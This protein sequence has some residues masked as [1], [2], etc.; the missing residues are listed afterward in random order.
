[1]AN[2]RP[3]G[4]ESKL[5]KVVRRFEKHI[6]RR[7]GLEIKLIEDGEVCFSTDDPFLDKKALKY[8]ISSRFV[9]PRLLVMYPGGND[10]NY[11]IYSKL[12][13][14]C[15]YFGF[16]NGI[17]ASFKGFIDVQAEHGDAYACAR[18]KAI[19]EYEEQT[20]KKILFGINDM[21]KLFRTEHYTEHRMLDERHKIEFSIGHYARTVKLWNS[22]KLWGENHSD[23]NEINS[24][25]KKLLE[26]G[27][28]YEPRPGKLRYLG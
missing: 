3:L 15:V 16:M 14:M 28:A 5:K 6:K 13:D 11:P 20:D 10:P 19:K 17:T 18:R 7:K 26:D 9:D 1:M 27:I 24:E 12:P 8:T 4:E 21:L 22:I 25:I 23:P 2:R